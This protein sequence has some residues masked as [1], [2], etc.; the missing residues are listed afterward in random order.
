[1]ISSPTPRRSTGARRRAKTCD[2]GPPEPGRG[3]PTMSAA[4][5]PSLPLALHW[6]RT[7]ALP[8]LLLGFGVVAAIFVLAWL[9][10]RWL[11][12]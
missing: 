7:P 9:V 8:G 12:S 5:L 6:S 1:M 4:I 2:P 3:S 10:I 11:G